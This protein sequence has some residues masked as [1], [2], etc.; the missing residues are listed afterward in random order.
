[1]FGKISLNLEQINVFYH[2][3]IEHTGLVI[4]EQDRESF[5]EKICQR[6]EKLKFNSPEDYY[7]LLNIDSFDGRQEWE[8]LV[9]FLTN[10]ESYFFRDQQQFNLLRNELLPEIIERNQAKKTIRICSAGCSTGQEPY[11]IAILLQELLPDF[12]QWNLLILGIDIN[13]IAIQEAEKAIYP[14]WSFRGVEKEIRQKYFREINNQYYLA[15]NIKKIVKFQQI[16]LVK[17]AFPQLDSELKDMDLIICRNVFIYFEAKAIAK[18]INKIYHTL[19]PLGYLITGH[20]ELAGQDLSSFNIQAFADSIVYQRPADTTVTQPQFININSSL[21]TDSKNKVNEQISLNNQTSNV[22]AR[23]TK[24]QKILSTSTKKTV[25]ESEAIASSSKSNFLNNQISKKTKP[26]ENKITIEEA[27]KDWH[28]KYYNLAI[29]KL[30]KI[31][32]K[33]NSNLQAYQLM[34]QI[35]ADMGKYKE[36]MNYCQQALEIDSF[37]VS[38]HYL[39]AHIAEEQ[40]N[41]SEAKRILKQIIYLERDFVA[42]YLDLGQIYRQEGDK[43]RAIK[44]Q[45]AALEILKNLPPDTK[46]SE[47]DNLTTNQLIM[48]LETGLQK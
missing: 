31:L 30:Q 5:S 2:L 35:Y 47:R 25:P 42:A 12:Q 36:A 27:E 26:S 39:L 13:Q 1:M 3:L 15:R 6:I 20:T 22:I 24:A 33:N 32:Q 18:V 11:S 7:Q 29:Q 4:R 28:Q 41:L 34:V 23:I 48:Q 46:I 40:G 21:V 14:P 19:Q 38:L 17:D 37:A 9:T 10:N 43:K 44:M 8:H 16:N 45:Q